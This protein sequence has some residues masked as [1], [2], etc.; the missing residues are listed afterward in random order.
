MASPPFSSGSVHSRPARSFSHHASILDL[1]QAVS[2]HTLQSWPPPQGRELQQPL[3]ATQTDALQ[4]TLHTRPYKV[5]M[6]FESAYD[7]ASVPSHA[8]AKGANS[9]VSADVDP[10]RPWREATL[11]ALQSHCLLLRSH[12]FFD[13][14]NA[15]EHLVGRLASCTTVALPLPQT[16]NEGLTGSPLVTAPQLSMSLRNTSFVAHVRRE[17]ERCPC[18]PA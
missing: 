11:R 9:V 1:I 7:A 6:D 3:T 5:I 2:T 16:F 10:D 8:R 17:V 18:F 13:R 4:R 15:I 14:A 12:G